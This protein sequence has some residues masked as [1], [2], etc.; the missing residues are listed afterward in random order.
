MW[1]DLYVNYSDK[2]YKYILL[3]IGDEETAED[4]THDTF[5][6]VK[7]SLNG[8]KGDS[9]YYTWIISIARNLVYDYW[10][11]KKKIGFI[12]FSISHQPINKETPDSILQKNE[13]VLELYK[14]IKKLKIHYQEVLIL[15]KIQELTL[16]ETAAATGWSISK[17]KTT[18]HRAMSALRGEVDIKE[19][20]DKLNEQ[21]LK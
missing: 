15:R 12:P 13:E 14:A 7:N 3:M 21:V 8:F 2:V 11:R 6:K 16:E 9:S 20:E 17:V 19:K 10:R 1:E 5:I 4:L 18:T